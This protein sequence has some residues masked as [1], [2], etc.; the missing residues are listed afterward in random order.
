MARSTSIGL[1]EKTNKLQLQLPSL[2]EE[3]KVAKTRL[4]VT[5][6]DSPDELIRDAGIETHTSKKL[7]PTD[8]VNQAENSLKHKYIVGVVI[9]IIMSLI[10]F[11][12]TYSPYD[13]YAITK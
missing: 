12:F 6:R 13:S 5:L 3:L 9:H 11:C 7:S 1:Y 8:S 2:V 10:I 4:M